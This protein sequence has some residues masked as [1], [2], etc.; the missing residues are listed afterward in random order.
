MDAWLCACARMC[1]THMHFRR[2]YVA[3]FDHANAHIATMRGAHS[4]QYFTVAPLCLS[5]SVCAPVSVSLRLRVSVP[6]TY[7]YWLEQVPTHCL[8]PLW[9]SCG[10]SLSVFLSLTIYTYPSLSRSRGVPPHSHNNT[11]QFR[12][13]EG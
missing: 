2:R 5:V 7:I 13:K 10:R 3:N 11:T 9:I 4:I 6:V 8:P 1:V 12:C